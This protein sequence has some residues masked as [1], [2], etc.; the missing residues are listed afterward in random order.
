MRRLISRTLVGLIR[1]LNPVPRNSGNSQSERQAEFLAKLDELQGATDGERSYLKRHASRMAETLA[2]VDRVQ[3][4]GVALELGSY[5]HMAWALEHVL[6]CRK[7]YCAGFGEAG[8]SLSKTV[9]LRGGGIYSKSVD[10]FDAERDVFPYANKSIDLVLACELIEHLGSDPLHMLREAHR[11]LRADGILILT[12][13]NSSSLTS[14]ANIL[15][16]VGN[17]YVYSLYPPKESADAG[18]VREFVPAEIRTLLHYAGFSVVE[19][20]T[21][22]LDDSW[23]TH[24]SIQV[25]LNSWGFPPDLRGELYFVAARKGSGPPRDG[26]P[27]SIFEGGL[28]G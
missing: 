24:R 23:Q 18:H 8:A 20:F 16:Q 10:L 22:Y 11:V 2:L 25:M 28:A 3:P 17:P 9:P 13:P 1:L 15:Y 7:V 27:S 4:G 26:Y 21:R 14:L 19:E 12:T 6:G 5:L